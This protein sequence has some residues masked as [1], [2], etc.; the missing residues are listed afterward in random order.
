MLKAL[1]SAQADKKRFTNLS[2]PFQKAILSALSE[3]ET[4]LSVR[5]EKN[6]STVSFM[7]DL[8]GFLAILFAIETN[9]EPKNTDLYM[10]SIQIQVERAKASLK[11]VLI[12]VVTKP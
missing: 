9:G 3:F 7:E 5:L 8:G 2:W 1:S 12:P 11:A 6:L 10:S 4:I